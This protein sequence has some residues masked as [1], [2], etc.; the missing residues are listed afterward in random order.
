MPTL[1]L[2]LSFTAYKVCKYGVFPGPYFP[3]FSPNIG[4]YGPEENPY[5]DTFHAVFVINKPKI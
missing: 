4:K 5:L 3:A 2:S 1:L